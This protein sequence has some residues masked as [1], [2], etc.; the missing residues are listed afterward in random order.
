MQNV[1]SMRRQGIFWL[2]T[3]SCESVPDLPLLRNGELPSNVVWVRGQQEA[4]NV[5]GYL[6]WQFVVAFSKKV[7]LA[8]VK[9]VFGNGPVQQYQQADFNFFTPGKIWHAASVLFN[10]KSESAD[11]YAN[12]TQNIRLQFDSSTGAGASTVSPGNLKIDILSSSVEFIFKN[13][14]DRAV[15]VDIYECVP[16]IKFAR[17]NPLQDLYTAGII[18]QDQASED[19]VVMAF[20]AG[21]PKVGSVTAGANQS[22]VC[23]GS[24][25]GP[26]IM[27]NL[28][29]QWT[30]EKRSMLLQPEEICAHVMKGPTGTLDFQKLN[31]PT[32]NEVD[33]ECGLKNWSKH[34]LIS[35]RL[36]NIGK[37]PAAVANTSYGG[38]D[39]PFLAN[40]LFGK[41]ICEVTEKFS[42]AIP[43]VA[44][45]VQKVVVA[46]APQELNLRKPKICITELNPANGTGYADTGLYTARSE[47]PVAETSENKDM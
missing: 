5:G 40:A 25:D 14:S 30:Y 23:M 29:W 46:G 33:T 15:F 1:F 19:K 8:G 3:L 21:N 20:A 38:R 12:K 35:V 24:C 2:C 36:D 11:V 16:K 31:N 10:D 18:V 4:G 37:E 32:T 42:M 39:Q 6:H 7:S 43:E 41:V 27:K 9:S 34:C 47:N 22:F 17:F 44:G 28:G 13:I 26:A 45:F